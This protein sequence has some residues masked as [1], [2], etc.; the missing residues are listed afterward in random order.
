M[1]FFV[2]KDFDDILQ[3]P[4]ISEDNF[5]IT[6]HYSIENYLVTP[7][8]FRIYLKRVYSINQEDLIETFLDD[9]GIAQLK[10]YKYMMPIISLI[11]IY[12]KESEHMDLEKIKLSNFFYLEEFILYRKKYLS[13]D[14]YDKIARNPQTKAIERNCIRKEKTLQHILDKCVKKKQVYNYAKLAQNR[15]QLETI[16][17]KKSFI[18]GKYEFW[19]LFEVFKNIDAQINKINQKSRTLNG[20]I[21]DEVKRNTIYSK[22]MEINPKNVFDFLPAKIDSPSDINAFLKLNYSQL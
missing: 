5:F 12:R 14:E 21:T 17:S 6:N 1:L 8:V 7:E 13:V 9:I 15:R 19:F 10:F 4:T 22:R 11:L 3:K 18:R 16:E 20:T 2:D